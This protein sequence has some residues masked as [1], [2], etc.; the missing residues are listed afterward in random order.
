MRTLVCVLVSA[1]ALAAQPQRPPYTPTADESR[2]IHDRSMELANLLAK[3]ERNPLYPDAA[4]YLKAATFIV[5][6]P[7]EFFTPAYVKDT[8]AALD[9]GIARA[10][11]LAAGH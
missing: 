4:V 9:T 2:Q 6:H 5:K 11:E 7:G 10:K 1:A 8:L 3:V